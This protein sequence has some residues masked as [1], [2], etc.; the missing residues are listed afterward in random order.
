MRFGIIGLKNCDSYNFTIEVFISQVGKYSLQFRN[1]TWK[2][3]I[4]IRKKAIPYYLSIVRFLC[5]NSS[6]L[7]RFSLSF[8]F[9]FVFKLGIL[10]ALYHKLS[11]N[12]W[13]ILRI[14]LFFLGGEKGTYSIKYLRNRFTTFIH[15]FECYANL[16][17]V[18]GCS[19]IY[20]FIH[21]FSFDSVKE[22]LPSFITLFDRICILPHYIWKRWQNIFCFVYFD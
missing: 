1:F 18:V 20:C 16:F 2:I 4:E 21:T 19:L 15:I 6:S 5:F 8:L 3:L 12:C 14:N 9:F 17:Q 7:F 22:S 10:I 11:G 13:R